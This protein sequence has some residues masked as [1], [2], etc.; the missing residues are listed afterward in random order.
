MIRE[1]ILQKLQENKEEGLKKLP[2]DKNPKIG[3][4]KDHDTLTMYHGT[5]EKNLGG[6]H[7]NGIKAPSEGSTAHNVSLAFDPHTAHGYASMS[8]GETTFRT[9]GKK[10][11][12]VPEEHR[13]VLV[14]HI[15]RHWAE[16]H[17]NPHMRGNVDNT[18]DKLTNHERYQQHVK[19]GKQDHEYYS[20]SE[21]RFPH[22]PREYIKGFMK[23]KD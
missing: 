9:A 16:K 12:H 13:A 5:H 4:W 11:E 10:A 1:K 17:M 7:K 22:I 20:L 23:K 15:P 8:G 19:S 3:W 2:W 14:M 18:R 21:L 6:I